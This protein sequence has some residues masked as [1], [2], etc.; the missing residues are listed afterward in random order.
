ML[1][2]T[3]RADAPQQGVLSRVYGTTS[4]FV[5]DKAKESMG[6]KEKAQTMEERRRNLMTYSS[7]I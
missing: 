6:R 3:Y 4:V 7:D 1:Q 2:E 5:R